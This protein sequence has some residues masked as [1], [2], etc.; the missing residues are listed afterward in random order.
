MVKDAKIMMISVLE[1]IKN[2]VVLVI[3]V[4]SK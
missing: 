1:L 4:Q 3:G 2:L